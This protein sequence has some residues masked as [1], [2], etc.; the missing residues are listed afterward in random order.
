MPYNKKKGCFSKKPICELHNNKEDCRA[1]AKT[2]GLAKATS[3]RWVKNQVE[4]GKN[5]VENKE[6]KFVLNIVLSWNNTLKR[7]LE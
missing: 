1:L 2:S 3:Y 6:V 4:I 7:I 5:A